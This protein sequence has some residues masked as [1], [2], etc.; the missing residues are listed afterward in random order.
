MYD[1]GQFSDITLSTDGTEKKLHKS[2]LVSCD[3]FRG[4]LSSE[5]QE[6]TTGVVKNGSGGGAVGAGHSPGA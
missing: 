3:C 6:A 5:F 4:M 2:V 1:T